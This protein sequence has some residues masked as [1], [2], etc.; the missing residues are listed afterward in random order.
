MTPATTSQ[1]TTPIV[2]PTTGSTIKLASLVT[3][4]TRS[5]GDRLAV[6]PLASFFV[7]GVRLVRGLVPGLRPRGVVWYRG[8]QWI[9]IPDHDGFGGWRKEIL[10]RKEF[11]AVRV[12]VLC[13][14]GT[15]PMPGV[16]CR[17]LGSDITPCFRGAGPARRPLKAEW[18]RGRRPLQPAVRTRVPLMESTSHGSHFEQGA[19]ERRFHSTIVPSNV[20]RGSFT[21]TS[22]CNSKLLLQ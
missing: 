22:S 14:R 9:W 4:V 20:I 11:R 2:T 18:D 5:L 10:C 17:Q 19:R 16:W 21:L 3:H 12:H 13:G 1:M 8:R 7:H 15:V 6:A